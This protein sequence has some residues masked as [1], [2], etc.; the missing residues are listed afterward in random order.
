[1]DMSLIDSIRFTYWHTYRADDDAL[2][3][4]AQ[5]GEQ[6][7]IDGFSNPSIRVFD[8]TDPNAVVE[9]LGR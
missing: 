9:V 4:T 1:M 3:F 5:G 8:I 7:S 6:V 2:R